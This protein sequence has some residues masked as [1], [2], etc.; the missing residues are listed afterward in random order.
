MC[1]IVG[2]VGPQSAS[3]ILLEGLRRLEYRGYDSAGVAVL[4]PSGELHLHKKAG[5]LKNLSDV[6]VSAEPQG[7]I[8]IGHTRWATHGVPNDENAHPHLDCT[9]GVTV[10]HNGI[11]ENYAELRDHLLTQGHTFVSQTDTEVLAHLIEEQI[12]SGADLHAAVRGA[13]RQ[14]RGAYA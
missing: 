4:S 14:V 10:V 5:K 11:I 12:A 7:C 2:Y 1:G 13:L 8:G 3:P 9:G 6:L